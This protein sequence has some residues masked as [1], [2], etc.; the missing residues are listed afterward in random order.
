MEGRLHCEEG[1]VASRQVG[2]E[3][4]DLDKPGRMARNKG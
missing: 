4:G 2:V 1:I 3:R